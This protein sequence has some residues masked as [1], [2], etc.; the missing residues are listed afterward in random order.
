MPWPAER[1]RR[2][3]AAIVGAVALLAGLFAGPR[4]AAAAAD[5]PLSAS[6]VAAAA[7]ADLDPRRG[8]QWALDVLEAEAVWARQQGN[9]VVVGV[10]DT[11]V[12]A[13]HEDLAGRVVRGWD[14]FVAGGSGA[15]DP[16]GH[17]T[18][19]AGVIG[20]AV[21]NCTGIAGFAPDVRIMPIRA[22]DQFRIGEPADVASGIDWAVDHGV[23]VLNLSFAGYTP[24][25]QVRGAIDRAV[26]QGVVV[27]ASAG[28][29][30]A[31]GNQPMY[32]AADSEV[33]SVAAVN[34]DLEH[35]WFS[36]ANEAVD[37]SA[38]GTQILVPAPGDGYVEQDGTSFAAPHVSALAAL[39][40]ARSPEATSQQ[41][42]DRLTLSAQDLP[43]S[44]EDEL[45]GT[46]LLDPLAAL[47]D[48]DDDTLARTWGVDRVA[49]AVS[50]ACSYWDAS[51]Q[52]VIARA[53]TYPDAL[54]GTPLA[55]T[56]DAPLLLT[57]S[58]D[59]PDG[60]LRALEEL[61]VEQVTLLGGTAALDE[62]VDEQL[63]AAGLRTDRIE[64]TDRYATAAAIA[65]RVASAPVPR[66]VVVTGSGFADAVAAGAYLGTDV[67]PPM[68]LTERGRVPDVTRDALEALAPQEIVVVGGSAVIED[69][70]VAELEDLSPSVRR[71]AGGNRYAT[72]EA[73]LADVGPSGDRPLVLATGAAFP[74]ALTAGS[75]AARLGAALLLVD[76]ADPAQA[77][78]IVSAGPWQRG[79]LLGG[80]AAVGE[81]AADVLAT[82]LDGGGG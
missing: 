58:D 16:N 59:V 63:R 37:V 50:V 62:D 18:G 2:P 45:H 75:L 30:Y 42:A 55:G 48:G 22:F 73:V 77:A 9:G 33:V 68:L 44:G 67:L 12:D 70:V 72:S 26:S 74:D 4:P 46:G 69:A 49:T 13:T 5:G 56:L 8:E 40:R 27:V 61:G 64:G 14:A 78:G 17:G 66:A 29:S 53:D 81:A 10:V 19:V 15:V 32:P 34:R 79:A 11:G 1:A 3:L 38:P 6:A 51:S 82:S 20:A 7:A 39:L 24:S 71:V 35:A 36:T 76:P 41:I 25:A 31:T 60:V 43:P 65:Q 80:P 47:D 57:G 52:A 28:N 21:T 54:A 23:D